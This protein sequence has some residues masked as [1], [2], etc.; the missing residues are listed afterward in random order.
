M[1]IKFIILA[2]ILALLLIAVVLSGLFR[3]RRQVPAVQFQLA[4]ASDQG[5][6]YLK[7]QLHIQ[8]QSFKLI[9]REIH[10]NIGLSLSLAKLYLS[11]L[12]IESPAGRQQKLDTSV[13]LIT[14]AINSLR[15]LSINLKSGPT[16]ELGLTESLEKVLT[17]IRKL[18][19]YKVEYNVTGQPV[20]LNTQQQSELLRIIQEALNNIIKHA[21]ASKIRVHFTY[22]SSG[23]MVDIIDDGIG[24]T[25]AA[26][27]KTDGSG[28]MN[29]SSRAQHLNGIC[30]VC[31]LPQG[32]TMVRINIPY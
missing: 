4:P 21:R 9:A 30:T 25:P 27:R 16:L 1:L 20:L 7:Q 24:I 15:D 6:H 13:D 5:I 3:N 28:L 2:T 11:S 32:G 29:M 10:D 14:N 22:G 26:E 12:S 19:L 18:N 17:R 8:E 31:A 23:V